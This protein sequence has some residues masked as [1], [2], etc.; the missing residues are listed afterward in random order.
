MVSQ[1]DGDEQ[2]IRVVDEVITIIILLENGYNNNICPVCY[3]D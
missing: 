1:I 3:L 2:I